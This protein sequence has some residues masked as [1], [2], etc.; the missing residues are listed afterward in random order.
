MSAEITKL[1]VPRKFRAWCED[2]QDG[3]QG[4]KPTVQKWADRHNAERH[5]EG[6]ADAAVHPKA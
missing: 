6:V 1:P 5:P 3:Y 4:G 2:C